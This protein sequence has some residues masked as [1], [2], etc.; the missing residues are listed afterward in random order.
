VL[1]V[2]VSALFTVLGI[3]LARG[4]DWKMGIATATFF[5]ACLAVGIWTLVVKSRTER[6][7]HAIRVEVTGGVPIRASLG[8]APAMAATFAVVGLVGGWA[9]AS[10]GP[11][12]VV[13]SYCVGGFGAALAV[14]F[15]LGVFPRPFIQFEPTG[16]R[17]G[18]LRDTCLLE[19]DNIARVASREI[20]GHDTVLF[21][22][23]DVE[24]LL[25]TVDTMGSREAAV[26]RL[27]SSIRWNRRLFGCDVAII[28]TQIGTDMAL[29]VGAIRLYVTDPD[30]RSALSKKAALPS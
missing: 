11:V 26:R 9:G 20:F 17:F 24:R 1:L 13:V 22:A 16:L 12:F 30:A 3:A 10:M 23:A 19:W 25:R 15:L 5:G 8:S 7:S 4:K 29:L 18:Q 14:L 27:S 28:P 21:V 2:A 6:H